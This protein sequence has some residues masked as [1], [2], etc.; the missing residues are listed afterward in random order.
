MGWFKKNYVNNWVHPLHFPD[1]VAYY[2][3]EWMWVKVEPDNKLRIGISDIGVKAVKRLDFVRLKTRVGK[4][5]K[6]GDLMGMVDTSKM[7]WEVIAPVSGKVVEVNPEFSQ[8]SFDVL[9]HDN[10][11]AGWLFVLEKV[12]ATDSELKTLH[13]SGTPECEKWLEAT[14]EKNVP[15]NSVAGF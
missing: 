4:E 6:K 3:E 15:L 13:K 5:V 8:G 10:Y 1:D 14:V 7:V 9:E 11:G 2:S 12:A